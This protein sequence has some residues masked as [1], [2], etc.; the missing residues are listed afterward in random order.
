M[1]LSDVCTALKNDLHCSAAELVYGTTLRLPAEFFHSS[2]SNTIDQVTYVTRLKEAMTKLQATP[3]HHHMKQRPF[4][5]SNLSRCT[6]VFVR[7]DAV[8]R[9]LEQPYH[10]P[11]KVIE[12]GAKTFTVDVHGN[13]EIISLD[14]LKQVHIEDSVTMDVT[15]TNDTL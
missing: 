6:H 4:V 13:P 9:S 5:S 7:Q 2:R 14:G 11:H 15:P 1:M 12:H 10:G 3:T 8:H